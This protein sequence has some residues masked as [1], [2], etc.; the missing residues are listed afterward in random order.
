MKDMFECVTWSG[1]QIVQDA[2]WKMVTQTNR[3]KY[4]HPQDTHLNTEDGGR[5]FVQNG[6]IHV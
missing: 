3:A 2:V 1:C 4:G 5:T 6:G